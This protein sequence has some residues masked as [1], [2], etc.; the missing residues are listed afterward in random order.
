MALVTGGSRGIGRG[1]ALRLGQAGARVAINYRQNADA[2]NEVLAALGGDAVA[3]ALQGD[4][5]RPADCDALVT[6]V[7]ERFGRLDVLVNNAGVTRD[8]LLLR[9]S[10]QDWDAVLDT[11]LKGAYLCTKLALRPMLRQ[12]W[13]R[14][15]NIASVVGITGNAGQANYAAAKAGLIAF[16]RSVAREVASRN[17]TVNAIAP[18]FITTEIT[19]VL[20]EGV[21]R[22][23]LAQIPAERFGAPEDVA[24]LAAFLASPAAT[25]IT[26][27]VIN[28]DG[29]MVTA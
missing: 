1:I 19:A 18:G 10:E 20:P 13:G 7:V 3:L 22:T 6:R 28:V 24:E 2:A 23:I 21:Q 11:N 9:M 17:I 8:N 15:L 12:R 5:A 4:V 26:G 29:G 16:T 27:Q 14:I 25:Y